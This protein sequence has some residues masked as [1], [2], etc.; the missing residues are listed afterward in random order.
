VNRKIFDLVRS[1][2]RRAVLRTRLEG[3]P[4]LLEQSGLWL[5]ATLVRETIPEGR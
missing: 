5:T 4:T 3:T 1:E 2:R